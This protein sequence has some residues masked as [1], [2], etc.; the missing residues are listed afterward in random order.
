MKT[1]RRFVFPV[2]LGLTLG[3]GALAAFKSRAAD[4]PVSQAVASV[5]ATA[6]NAATASISFNNTE[7]TSDTIAGQTYLTST[8]KPK[9]DVLFIVKGAMAMLNYSNDNGLANPV[10]DGTEVTITARGRIFHGTGNSGPPVFDQAK[11]FKWRIQK[12]MG[13]GYSM[14]LPIELGGVS[15][16]PGTYTAELDFT[17]GNVDALIMG[18]SPTKNSIVFLTF[19]VK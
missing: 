4:D 16:T 15:L 8:A 7:M 3:L 6:T 2:V 10:K 19:L 18:G 11:P 12:N 9:A 14:N 13:P 17:Y 1:F 5:V